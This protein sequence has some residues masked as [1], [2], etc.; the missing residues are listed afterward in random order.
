MA[1]ACLRNPKET[2]PRAKWSL[3]VVCGNPERKALGREDRVGITRKTHGEFGIGGL[4]YARFSIPGPDFFWGL[5]S[6]VLDAPMSFGKNRKMRNLLAQPS[7]QSPG[8]LSACG[9]L[10]NV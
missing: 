8:L 5:G 1:G 9:S 10:E 3:P 4:A 2:S 6:G 7:T